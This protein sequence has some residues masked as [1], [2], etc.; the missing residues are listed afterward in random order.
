MFAREVTMHLKPNSETKFSQAIE[1]VIIP[2]LR[3]Q[4]GFKDEIALV[5]SLRRA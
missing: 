2:L 4:N 1:K 3:L 5:G